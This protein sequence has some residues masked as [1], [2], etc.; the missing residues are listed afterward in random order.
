MTHTRNLIKIARRVY[1]QNLN[2]DLEALMFT[3]PHVGI[4]AAV[5]SFPRSIET[6]W[7]LEWARKQSMATTYLAKN[8]QTLPLEPR[9]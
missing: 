6:K 8:V 5:Q 2:R 3:H 4:P 9:S 1:L 7:D